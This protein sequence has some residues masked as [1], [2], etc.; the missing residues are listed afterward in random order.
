MRRAGLASVKRAFSTIQLRPQ[1]LSPASPKW[2]QN[3]DSKCL[4]TFQNG[5]SFS[6]SQELILSHKFYSK[7]AST[8]VQIPEESQAVLAED[9]N[10]GSQALNSE[11]EE[12]TLP[13]SK[14]IHQTPETKKWKI[15]QTPEK[16]KWK[17]V[18]AIKEIWQALERGDVDME[19]TLTQLGVQ[20]TPQLV[21]KVLD[22][23]S[24]PR[25]AMRFFQWAKA[26]QGFRHN[27]ST[28]DKLVDVLG[29]SRDFETLQRVLSE[30][31]AESCGYSDKTFS[32]ATVSHNPNLLNEVMEMIEKLEISAR[33]HAYE[34]LVVS[35]CKENQLDAAEV[36]LQ[37]MASADCAPKSF[38]F[39][40]LILFCC[41]KYEMDKLQWV[42]KMMKMNGCPPGPMCF[43]F[44][45][46]VLCKGE[47]FA[48]AAELLE[49]MA[50]MGCKPNAITYDI[51]I[52]AACMMGRVQGALQ[53]FDRLKEEG[54]KSMYGTDTFLLGGLF[55]IR[56]FNEAHSFLVHQSGKDRVLDLNNYE[57]LIG[58]CSKSGRGQEAHHLLMEM[59]AMDLELLDDQLGNDVLHQI[60][61]SQA[62]QYSC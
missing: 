26:Q 37:K 8:A 46:S 14:K 16:K 28:Y 45:L 51:M 38:S 12:N 7:D 22:T 41:Q 27:T 25:S 47:R 35:F 43:N 31:F 10:P 9:E 19:E 3:L 20:I 52:R 61:G 17:L 54:I 6:R 59:K 29:H 60:Q 42:F 11:E 15:H 44:V 1:Q 34:K 53:L 50:K 58:V 23:T 32:F 40:P 30:R 2:H 21:K 55:Q 36:V 4:Q 62:M 13:Q 39:R 18:D 24:S 48:Q 49:S 5:K 33:R 57:Y 56:G